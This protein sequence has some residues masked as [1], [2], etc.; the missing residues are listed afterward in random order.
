LNQP[1]AQERVIDKPAEADVDAA[2]GGAEE[3]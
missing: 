3:R 2:E 1:L